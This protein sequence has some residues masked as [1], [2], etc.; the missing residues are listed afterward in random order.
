M[1]GI[2][3]ARARRTDDHRG[4]G[5]LLPR[6][7]AVANNTTFPIPPSTE[8]SEYQV[9]QSR[10]FAVRSI[11]ECP[12]RAVVRRRVISRDGGGPWPWK[13]RG[14][15]GTAGRGRA[16]GREEDRTHDRRIA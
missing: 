1:A 8:V 9:A 11:R 15:A 14:M 7:A 13:L 5:P 16:R 10:P 6:S 3:E 2:A 12:A 4:F